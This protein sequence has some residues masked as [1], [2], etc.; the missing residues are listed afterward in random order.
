VHIISKVVY[1]YRLLLS[2]LTILLAMCSS[3][4]KPFLLW[5]LQ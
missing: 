4:L 2:Y 1:I 3:W 5:H